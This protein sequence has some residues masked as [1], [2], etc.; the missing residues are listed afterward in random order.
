MGAMLGDFDAGDDSAEVKANGGEDA[1][2]GEIPY[3]FG[4]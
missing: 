3:V 1:A 4:R 2:H